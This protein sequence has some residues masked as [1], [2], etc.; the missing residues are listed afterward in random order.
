MKININCHWFLLT[1]TSL[2]IH[3][4]ADCKKVWS[5]SGLQRIAGE[6]KVMDNTVELKKK[7]GISWLPVYL[8]FAPGII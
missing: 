1:K 4:E 8:L 2:Y 3:K 6:V 7:T 5:S